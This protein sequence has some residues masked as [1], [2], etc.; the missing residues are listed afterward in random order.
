[1]HHTPYAPTA[2]R[3]RPLAA[4]AVAATALLLAACSGSTGASSDT[5]PR[6][7]AG[8][9]GELLTVGFPAA[10]P[11]L[12]PAKS[13]GNSSIFF[14]EVAYEPL[15]V[16]GGDGQYKPGLA[17]GWK[18]VGTDNTT[19][20]LT[21]REGVKFSDGSALTAQA[22]TDHFTYLQT[23]GGQNRA[24]FA[25]ATITA[26][27][28]LEVTIKTAA[29]NPDWP[30]NLTQ[31]VMAGEV[32]SPAGLKSPESLGTRTFG[33]GPYVLSA[34]NTTIGSVYTY[35][36]NPN[37]YNPSALHYKK[38]VI[39][40]I[41]SP[42]ATLQALQ[43]GQI[44]LALGDASTLS[45]AKTAGFFYGPAS[46]TN[47]VTVVT[48]ADRGGTTAKPL[49]DVRV[50]QA[51]NY[52]TDRD[53]IV[54]ALF[55][56]N[57]A[58]SQVATAGRDGY[59]QT[60]ENYYPHDVAKAKDLL[61]QAGYAGGFSMDMVTTTTNNQN[62]LAQALA[63]QWKAIGV[64]VKIN[65]I[66]NGNAY[67]QQA[68]SGKF[69]AFTNNVNVRPIATLGTSLF[70]PNAAYNPYHYADPTLQG[71]YGQDVLASGT[72]KADLDKQIVRHLVEQAWF[73][74]VV[75]QELPTYVSPKVTGA[76]VRPPTSFVSLYELQPAA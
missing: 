5:T 50:R 36:P 65:E 34:E 52:A 69:P 7:P 71:L 55:P 9:V 10:P 32:I 16:L 72:A 43:T 64:T 2:R 13:L 54:K 44:D 56:G 47:N 42:Q 70:L 35:L 29:P 49:A 38:V 37:Y 11:T 8:K 1:M 39:K 28:P 27:G 3:R 68:L 24:L 74:P 61:A 31:D 41:Q 40:V 45:A 15:I 4:T 30:Y 6:K 59:D 58:T 14:N 48:L 67:V 51:L 57:T 53:A 33:A 21:L 66:A 23:Q 19:F 17:T 12:D 73:V 75:A 62:L 18:Y 26:T 22:V 25:G 76:D 46:V 60:L 20:V 63:Q